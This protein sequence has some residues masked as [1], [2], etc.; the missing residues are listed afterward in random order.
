MDRPWLANYPEGVPARLPEHGYRNLPDILDEAFR[1]FAD[2]PAYHFMG[3]AL[4][5]SDVDRMSRDFAVFLQSRG[6][7]KGDRVALMM[8]NAFQYP[9]AVAGILRAGLVVVN[10]NPLYTERELSHQ[11]ADCG[12]KAIVV[13]ENMAATLAACRAETPARDRGGH[14]A[15]GTPAVSEG[16]DRRLRP[17]PGEAARAALRACRRHRIQGRALRWP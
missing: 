16:P 3:S 1:S 13:L 14:L 5:F 8:P 17:A 12:A 11:L 10:V 6:L 7:K 4:R 15:R 9:I 2:R